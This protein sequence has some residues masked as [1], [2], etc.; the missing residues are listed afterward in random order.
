MLNIAT[1][2]IISSI[3]KS[4]DSIEDIDAIRDIEEEEEDLNEGESNKGKSISILLYL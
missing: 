2:D 1:Q 3:I 4:E